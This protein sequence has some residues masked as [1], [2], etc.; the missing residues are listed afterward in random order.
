MKEHVLSL[1]DFGMPKVFDENDSMYVLIIRLLLLEPGKFQ[2]HPEMGVGI[3]SRYRYKSGEDI[4]IALQ[5]DINNQ[6]NKYLP[7][8]T[9][10]DVTL[11]MQGQVLGI[12]IDTRDGAYVVSYDT[13][14]DVMKAAAT[15]VLDSLY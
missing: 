8:L 6:I 5:N 2:S 11:T 10:T 1:N 4:L 9:A 7:E 12:I 15:N 14:T 13:T 3:K